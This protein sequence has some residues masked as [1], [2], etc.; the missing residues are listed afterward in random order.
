[1]FIYF[2]TIDTLRIAFH[3]MQYSLEFNFNNT[4]LII[5]LVNLLNLDRYS[6]KIDKI[7]LQ[8]QI[9]SLK[10]KEEPVL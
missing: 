1:M 7:L 2:V 5:Q 8:S 4:E 10:Q 9:N 3:F 6:F